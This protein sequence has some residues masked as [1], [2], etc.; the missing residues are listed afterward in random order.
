MG[1]IKSLRKGSTGIGFTFESLIGKS[2]DALCSPDFYD[3]EI[4]THRA[5]SKGYISLFNYNPIGSTSYELKRILMKYG[6]A[7]PKYKNHN[8]INT[9]IYCNY[10]KTVGFNYRFSLDVNFKDQRVY[11]LIFDLNGNLIDRES[12]WEFKVLKQKLYAKI[13][14]L[15]YIEAN[16]K[17]I[18]HIEY[19]KYS[20][21]EFYILKNFNTFI[22]L[23]SISKIRISFLASYDFNN[24]IVISHG[25]SFSIKPE[26]IKL[27]FK[28]AHSH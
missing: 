24:D 13:R 15:A 5:N 21:I 2:E 19:F 1:W 12:Y 26:N 16:T 27:L 4:K 3:I 8:I 10:P 28:P 25:V 17:Y 18:N 6:Y 23:L 22:Y 9:C 11:L 7:S 20:S 14:Y